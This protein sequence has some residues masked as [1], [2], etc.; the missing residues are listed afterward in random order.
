[1]ADLMADLRSRLPP[2]VRPLSSPVVDQLY[3]ILAGGAM[4]DSRVQRLYVGYSGTE[5]FARTRDRSEA[6]D[7]FEATVRFDVAVR[8]TR[9]LFVHAGAEA[10]EN[11]AEQ[12]RVRLRRGQRR[13]VQDARH[14]KHD[15]EAHRDRVDRAL[16]EHRDEHARMK[17]V[18]LA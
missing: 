6:L 13:D 2:E 9:S 1:M 15:D 7:L 3:S 16:D 4:P 11:L 5:Q 17:F 12:A 10:E 14:Q 8:S 18:F